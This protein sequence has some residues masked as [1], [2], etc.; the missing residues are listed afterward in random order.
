MRGSPDAWSTKL[1]KAVLFMEL[2]AIRA[3][4]CDR[5]IISNK[6]IAGGVEQSVPR[7]SVASSGVSWETLGGPT[8]SPQNPSTAIDDSRVVIV[9]RPKH[10]PDKRRQGSKVWRSGD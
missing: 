8:R 2:H 1:L 4:S 3:N 7:L 6:G 5:C 10:A 9:R